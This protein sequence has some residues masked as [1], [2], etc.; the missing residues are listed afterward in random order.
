MAIAQSELRAVADALDGEDPRWAEEAVAD[1]QST[2][3]ERKKSPGLLLQGFMKGNALQL[4]R[5]KVRGSC[6]HEAEDHDKFFS[7]KD[8]DIVAAKLICEDCPVRQ[9]CLDYAM[10]YGENDGIWG[11]LTQQE[12]AD[13]Q[14]FNY[15]LAEKLF[16]RLLE[17]PIESSSG[18]SVTRDVAILLDRS[19]QAAFSLIRSL[20]AHRLIECEWSGEAK[21]RPARIE[22]VPEGRN[23]LADYLEGRWGIQPADAEGETVEAAEPEPEAEPKLAPPPAPE[24]RWTLPAKEMHGWTMFMEQDCRCEECCKAFQDHLD[25][26]MY[27]RAKEVVT[28]LRI[29]F[30][31]PPQR[32]FKAESAEQA[33][34]RVKA[35]RVARNNRAYGGKP[36]RD[37]EEVAR[38]LAASKA[39]SEAA[40]QKREERNA[41]R[42]R[43]ADEYWQRKR[44]EREAKA[45]ERAR[46]HAEQRQSD[47]QKILDALPIADDHGRA[48]KRLVVATGLGQGRFMEAWIR[49]VHEREVEYEATRTRFYEIRRA[50]QPS[51]KQMTALI[52]DAIT[53]TF[54][55]LIPRRPTAPKEETMP[56]IK[57]GPA[58]RRLLGFLYERP[59]YR[60]EGEHGGSAC[61][62]HAAAIGSSQTALPGLLRKQREL[63]RIEW[64][65]P[66]PD[67]RKITAFFLTDEGVRVIETWM[68]ER[69]VSVEE[70][71]GD[72]AEMAARAAEAKP[73]RAEA[74]QPLKVTW[75]NGVDPT[76]L[77]ERLVLRSTAVLAENR[78]LKEWQEEA[79]GR[80]D[81]LSER[82]ETLASHNRELGEELRASEEARTA[83]EHQ[84]R[85]LREML[86]ETE[87]Q[88]ALAQIQDLPPA[89]VVP[90]HG[91][92]PSEQPDAVD[93]AVE[94]LVGGTTA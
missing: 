6:G 89:P 24:R 83:A 87:A 50:G 77:L 81:N 2:M 55:R 84:T 14:P 62:Q 63:G 69:G 88:L 93:E 94:R 17:G 43:Q 18:N 31:N 91:H 28:A 35:E 80:I 70:L 34:A 20:M 74:E 47:R 9:E 21:P 64:E 33:Q 32:K 1:Y 54:D 29:A 40:R 46:L 92:H 68:E 4:R 86:T 8:E 85:A 61:T 52:E 75:P 41:E 56:Q 26:P 27:N 5:L 76:E 79:G 51:L 37:P 39:A 38:R 15:Q 73:R 66:T 11:G 42:R 16:W 67:A 7:F 58:E 90:L 82:V 36:R 44:E 48:R 59:D 10:E 78:A 30:G 71:R 65:K 60:C 49:L 72:K 25:G 57:L 12:R 23:W 3:E 53:E 19:S 13:L 22:I 45:A